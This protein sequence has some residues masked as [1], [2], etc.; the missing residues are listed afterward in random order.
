MRLIAILTAFVLSFA[1]PATAQELRIGMQN[2]ITSVD[3][4]FQNYGPNNGMSRHVFDALVHFDKDDNLQPGLAESWKAINETTWEFKLRRGVRFH[5]GSELTADD[6]VFSVNRVRSIQRSPNPFTTYLGKR[7][8]E[9]V[10]DYTVRFTN[11]GPDP[12]LVNNVPQFAISSA[13][14]GQNATQDDFNSGRAA[15]GTGP[16]KFIRWT[17]SDRLILERNDNYWGEAGLRTRRVPGDP[18][19]RRPGRGAAR[20]RC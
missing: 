16:Y 19:R 3:P 12:L 2:E 11:D 10:D 15:I 8:I 20:R 7:T 1:G 6:V 17:P 14:A 4:H 9:K 13:R 18:E 5:D